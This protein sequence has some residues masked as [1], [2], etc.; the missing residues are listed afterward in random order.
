MR[1]RLIVLACAFTLLT[2]AVDVFLPVC[3]A[4]AA[5]AALDSDAQTRFDAATH[6]FQDGDYEHA[7]EEFQAAYGLSERPAMLYNIS[8]CYERLANLPQ[9]IQYLERY[10]HTLSPGDERTHVEVRLNHMYE[11]LQAQSTGD[12]TVDSPTETIRTNADGSEETSPRSPHSERE[13]RLRTNHHGHRT[14]LALGLTSL[15]T[16]I[17]SVSFGALAWRQHGRLPAACTDGCDSSARS[18]LKAY[19]LTADTALVLSIGA[20]VGALVAGLR[21]RQRSERAVNSVD[22]AINSRA[23]LLV[24]GGSF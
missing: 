23:A 9:A 24:V 1:N 13:S 10:A 21:H 11:R 14:T 2:M 16:A 4:Q 7:L 8:L 12:S 18:R 3:E 19:D 6:Y 20:G 5:N 17:V 22:V 15:A